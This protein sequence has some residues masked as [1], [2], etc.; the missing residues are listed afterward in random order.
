VF[1]LTFDFKTL[2]LKPGLR[3]LMLGFGGGRGFIAMLFF[4][5]LRLCTD[6][7]LDV[8]PGTGRKV[9][10]GGGGGLTVNLVFCFG[11]NLFIQAL[12][13]DLDQAEQ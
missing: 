8:W 9:C 5:K 6:F 13:L 1:G 3:L 4:A 7:Q 10:G 2:N 12:V 11:P